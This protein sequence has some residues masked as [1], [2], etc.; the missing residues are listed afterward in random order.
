MGMGP[1][2]PKMPSP[3]TEWG[4]ASRGAEFH[5]DPEK[6]VDPAERLIEKLGPDGAVDEI[7]ARLEADPSNEELRRQANLLLNRLD[8]LVEKFRR[9]I[10][11]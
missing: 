3:V 2:T 6:Q 4:R 10:S 8:E 5:P 11:H 1:E 7:T 9:K